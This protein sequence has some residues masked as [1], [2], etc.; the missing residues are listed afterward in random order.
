MDLAVYGSGTGPQPFATAHDYDR[1]L[2]RMRQFPRW[3]DGAIAHDAR[4]HGAR[5]HAAAPGH[6]QGGA[7]AARHRHADGRGNIFWAPIAAM[8][9]DIPARGAPAHQRGLR[10]GAHATKCCPPT[11]GSRISSSATIYR[12]R[13][14]RSAGATCPT[15]R[16]GIAGASAAPPPWTCRRRRSTSSASRKWRASA[17][18]CSR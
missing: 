3:A 8:P 16:P 6:G 12:R 15:A 13:A 9:A 11:R 7:A 1:F 2:A 10:G 4:G 18:K 14:P 17:A 5:H